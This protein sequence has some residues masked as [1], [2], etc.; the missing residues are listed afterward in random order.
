MSKRIVF[1]EIER[2]L[3]AYNLAIGIVGVFGAEWRP[4]DETLKHNGAHGPPIA[5]ERVALAGKD[6]GGYVIRC[7][8]SRV[9]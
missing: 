2:L 7:P 5:A 9:R 3:P 8:N 6:F 1:R 4:T